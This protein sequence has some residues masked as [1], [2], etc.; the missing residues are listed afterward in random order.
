[1]R[2][3][4]PLAVQAMRNGEVV[5]KRGLLTHLAWYDALSQKVQ[6]V[7]LDEVA[8]L[9]Q[10]LME[11]DVPWLSFFNP[12][13]GIAFGG[14]QL[15]CSSAGLEHLPRVLNPHYY[16]I[17]GPVI[18]WARAMNFTFASSASQLMVEAP[19]GTLFW[20]KWAYVL[21]EPA[22]GDNPHAPLLGWRKKLTNPLRV[23]LVEEVEDR[24][25][26]IGTEIYIDPSKTGWEE[27]DTAK[28]HK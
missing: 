11:V 15:E 12:A 8:D 2:V 23:R 14:I 13:T 25:P 4:Q 21:Y 3:N 22:D 19:K 10:H 24:V 27:R 17:V 5:F 9:D 7:H 18:Y 26:T 28:P 16:V 6:T 1:M 20:E